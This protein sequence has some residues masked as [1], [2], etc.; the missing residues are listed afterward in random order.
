MRHLPA[1]RD[2]QTSI[3]ES[4]SELASLYSPIAHRVRAR[5]NAS[6]S[7]F[8]SDCELPQLIPIQTATRIA[9]CVLKWGAVEICVGCSKRMTGFDGSSG[10]SARRRRSK[11][12]DDMKRRPRSLRALSHQ[13][14]MNL[15]GDAMASRVICSILAAA[16]LLFA[17]CRQMQSDLNDFLTI[18]RDECSALRTWKRYRR[19]Y[20]GSVHYLHDFGFGFQRGYMDVA[21]GGSGCPPVVP[22]EEY[23][24]VKYQT[25]SGE[26]RIDAWFQ[27]YNEGVAVAEQLG[28]RG[29]N[30]IQISPFRRAQLANLPTAAGPGYAPIPPTP[31]TPRFDDAPGAPLPQHVPSANLDVELRGEYGLSE[32]GSA[33]A[34][35]IAGEALEI[36][37]GHGL[38]EPP[39]RIN[40]PATNVDSSI[41]SGSE[42]TESS[43]ADGLP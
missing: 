32:P 41:E 20:E 33:A 18:K 26:E 19:D 27:G 17:G 36:Q 13:S 31:Q 38:S 22:A 14:H 34:T 39:P 42:G 2:G 4:D 21:A 11:R 43:S 37:G 24:C 9:R 23:W 6:R 8:F 35:S 12:Y 15:Q 29:R 7:H 3:D 25:A 5:W 10:Y 1:R 30:Y 28:V 16:A 40:E